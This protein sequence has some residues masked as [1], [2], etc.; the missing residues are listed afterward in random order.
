MSRI[1]EPTFVRI[2]ADLAHCVKRCRY[3]QMLFRYRATFA[4]E[5]Y[6]RMVECFFEYKEQ[7]GF[8]LRPDLGPSMDTTLGVYARDL[9]Y[10]RRTVWDCRVILMGGIRWMS[11]RELTKWLRDRQALGIEMIALSYLGYGERHDYF[12]NQPGH[13]AYQINLQK[14]AATLG[15]RSHEQLL[16]VES[17]LPLLEELVERL[18]ETGSTDYK[19]RRTYH[20]LYSGLGR[21]WEHERVTR[22]MLE[23]L[24]DSVKSGPSAMTIGGQNENGR[25]LCCKGSTSP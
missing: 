8:G 17:V 12:N 22:A 5:R 11:D 23:P 6:F 4:F 2:S 21:R 9:D 19:M 20:L 14:I 3:C 7:T 16:L 15:L 13:F 24:P 25:N 18:D 10:I 1:F